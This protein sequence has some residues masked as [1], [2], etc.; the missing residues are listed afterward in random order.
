MKERDRFGDIDIYLFDQLLKERLHSTDRVLDAGC[1][2]GRN[3]IYLMR[4]G[5]DVWGVDADADAV[6]TVQDL[7]AE[8]APGLPDDRFQVAR[9]EA[10]PFPD[11]Q[12]TVV[13]ASAVLHFARDREHFAAMLRELWRVLAPGG[14][15]WCRLASTIGMETKIRE[16]PDGRFRLPDGTVR[17]LVDEPAL[18]QWARELGGLLLDPLKTTIV[19][20]QRAMTTWVLRKG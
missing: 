10:L 1:G 8:L 14:M 13:L 4:S 3:L 7:A 19:H 9:L 17:Y 5:Y 11:G 2:H 18:S 12:F 6:Q 20:D 16:T 15:L